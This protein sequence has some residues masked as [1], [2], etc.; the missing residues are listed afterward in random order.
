MLTKA[1]LQ[2]R[3]A[4]FAADAVK[5][6][7]EYLAEPEAIR[8]RTAYLKSLR[9]ERAAVESFEKQKAVAIDEKATK[10]KVTKPRKR[11]LSSA[12]LLG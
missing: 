5:A 9:L 4:L 11:V 12:A 8:V 10:K 3:R 6:M 7:A 2:K 1:E